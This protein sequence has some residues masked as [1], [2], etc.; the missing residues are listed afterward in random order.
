MALTIRNR[1]LTIWKLCA[2]FVKRDWE[3]RDYPVTVKEQPV[4]SSA[5]GTR[6]KPQHFMAFILGWG[7]AGTG[8][9]KE[10]ALRE[11]QKV[12][13][14]VKAERNRTGERLPRPGTAV[15]VKFAASERVNAHPDLSADF[16]QRVLGLD[17][18]WISDESSPLGFPS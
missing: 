8:N 13:A 1:A 15:P 2:S 14:N 9:T 18:A 17:W 6:L 7:L 3:F 12:F 4:E 16:I 10:D 11:L 5:A